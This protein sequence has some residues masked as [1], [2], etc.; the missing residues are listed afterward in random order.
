MP[1]TI[2]WI[3]RDLRLHDNQA[4]HAARS[5]NQPLLPLFILDPVLMHS[6]YVGEKRLA[7]LFD[8]LRELDRSLQERG[9]R[10]IVR[11]GHPL[12]ILKALHV[13]L[14]VTAIYAE[15][16][17]SP[18]ARRRDASIGQELPLHLAP[19]VSILPI[20]SVRKPDGSPYTVYTPFNRRWQ[21]VGMISPTDLCEAPSKLDTPQHI[22][23]E[24]LPSAPR[25]P[26][27]S[28]FPAGEGEALRRFQHFI[29]SNHQAMYGYAQNR[30]RPDIDG[31]SQLSPYIRFG[32]I[33]MRRLALAAQEAIRSAPDA[34]AQQ[35]A[36]TWLDELLW[37]EF[38][39][40]ILYFFPHV[41]TSSYFPQYNAI[42]WRNDAAHFA[43][44]CEGQTGY[45]YIDAAMRQLAA[46]GWMHNRARM[47]VASF[48]T[49]DLLID[50]R[51]GER[52]FMQQLLDGDPAANNGGWQWTAGSGPS[53]A[54][55]FRVMNP[56]SQG[57]KFDP[58]GVYVRRWVPELANVATKY[59]HTPWL[60]PHSEQV[61]SHCQIG[62]DYPHPLVAH[63]I[64]RE[65]AIAAYKTALNR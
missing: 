33:S 30:N 8:G 64:A 4:L 45:P 2:W 1:L 13:E 16:D 61:R 38:Y 3:R 14:D 15:E 65:A 32:M 12:S 43:A 53:A 59:I 17:T 20:G 36:Q 49:K 48:L 27:S 31:T 40:S 6:S 11:R 5:Q 35:G 7:F 26:P 41:R 52:W 21:A 19:G 57:E 22:T 28:P 55:Y 62:R 18:Y 23:S 37:R 56:I 50:W 29:Q 47:A 34:T 58:A 24:P 60:M 25:H 44:W 42:Q 46:T 51:W 39:Q 10:L 54:P 9:S 63:D